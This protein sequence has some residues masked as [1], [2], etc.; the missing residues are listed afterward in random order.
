MCACKA[1]KLSR[2]QLSV[3]QAAKHGKRHDFLSDV[4]LDFLSIGRIVSQ[5]SVR[6]NAMIIVQE[7]CQDSV[8]LSFAEDDHVIQTVAPKSPYHPFHIRILPR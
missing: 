2:G 5:G 1:K 3:M 4:A 8:K 6:T 7:F